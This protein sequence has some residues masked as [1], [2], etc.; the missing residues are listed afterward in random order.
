MWLK[1]IDEI[2]KYIPND[3]KWKDV[4]I[5]NSALYVDGELVNLNKGTV[6]DFKV[7]NYALTDE[8]IAEYYFDGS[9]PIAHDSS[10]KEGGIM[11]DNE[12]EKEI[13]LLKKVVELQKRAMLGTPEGLPWSICYPWEKDPTGMWDHVVGVYNGVSVKL[14]VNG[15]EYVV[16]NKDKY[17]YF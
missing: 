16:R 10:G 3:N 8:E 13:K 9:D 12:M 5:L 17:P 1:N 7:L 6:T 2:S 4:Q 14:Y 15:V 11:K